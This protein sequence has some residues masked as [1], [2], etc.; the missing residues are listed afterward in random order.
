MRGA[1]A[2]AAAAAF[3]GLV[4]AAAGAAGG[5]GHCVSGTPFGAPECVQFRGEDAEAAAAACA[6]GE[7]SLPGRAGEFSEGLCPGYDEADFAGECEYATASGLKVA[8]IAATGGGNTCAGLLTSCEQITGGTWTPAP[9][10]N[11]SASAGAA[12]AALPAGGGDEE[13]FC[14]SANTFTGGED[15]VQ[16]PAGG[17]LALAE[18]ACT[19]GEVSMP[20]QTGEFSRGRCTGYASENFAGECVS[21]TD[22]GQKTA[23]VTELGGMATCDSLRDQLCPYIPGGSWVPGT[24][25]GGDG[26]SEG[27]ETEGAADS[28]A[29]GS[30]N[31]DPA[32]AAGPAGGGG[33]EGFCISANTFTGGEDCVQFPAGGDLALAEEACTSGEVSMPGQTGEFSRGRCTGYAS[34]NFAG[35]CVSE[36]DSGQKTALVLEVGGQATCEVLASQVCPYV[37]GGSWAPAPLCADATAQ[38]TDRPWWQW[39]G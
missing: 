17:D 16:F 36:T 29:A 34:E 28:D 39:W 26:D 9:R 13:G 25:C 20:G 38:S 14:I 37:P 19:S 10:C 5:A 33:E 4:C 2:A 21:E 11:S 12:P 32:P 30:E 31:A 8:A 3:G 6:D 24:N 23:L 35:E 7:V 27:A 18:E 1:A 15:C 22:S